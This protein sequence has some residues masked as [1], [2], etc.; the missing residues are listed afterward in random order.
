ME[1]CRRDTDRV[2][3]PDGKLLPAKGH[4]ALART[5]MIDFL[6]AIVPVQLGHAPRL[7]NGL[8][9]AEVAAGM[10]VRMHQLPDER[11]ILGPVCRGRRAADLHPCSRS[12]ETV[13]RDGISGLTASRARALPFLNSCPHCSIP[14]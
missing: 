9:Q 10:V 7:N 14:A 3:G 12:P 5:D 2:S 13:Q 1:C 6:A 4:D 8:G 11:T